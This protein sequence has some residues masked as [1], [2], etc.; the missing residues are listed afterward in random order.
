MKILSIEHFGKDVLIEKLKTITLNS[1][2]DHIKIYEESDIKLYD[3][4][5]TNLG[6]FPCQYYLMHSELEKV[7]KLNY[8]LLEH[9]FDMFH[10]DGYLSIKLELP[11]SNYTGVTTEVVIDLLPPIIEHVHCNNGNVYPVV[12]DGMHRLY[13]SMLEH[14][15]CQ[16]VSISLSD[17]IEKFPYYAYPIPNFNKPNTPNWSAVKIYDSLPRDPAFVKRWPRIENHKSLYRNFNAV[18]TGVSG[19][20]TTK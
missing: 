20:H 8:K 6:I 2:N 9:G 13:L 18:F 15:P 16:V 1:P 4:T 7:K 3:S 5:D 12:C 11:K 10:L 19:R 14:N 17:A